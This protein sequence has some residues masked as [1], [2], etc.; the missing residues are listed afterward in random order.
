VVVQNS[1]AHKTEFT[2]TSLLSISPGIATSDGFSYFHNCS[3]EIVHWCEGSDILTLKEMPVAMKPSEATVV[4]ALSDVPPA[5]AAVSPYT[6]I[7][8]AAPAGP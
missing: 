2:I 5:L 7:V 6:R 4:D 8:L 3:W 1:A